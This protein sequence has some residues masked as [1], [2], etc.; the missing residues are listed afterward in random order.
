MH[1]MFT[2]CTVGNIKV[3]RYER[4]LDGMKR[5]E[6]LNPD[7]STCLHCDLRKVAYF[8]ASVLLSVNEIN[9]YSSYMI[10]VRVKSC[11]LSQMSDTLHILIQN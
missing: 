7:S 8:W 1:S 2:L 10:D 4:Q 5:I 3:Y 9:K 6:T 11:E